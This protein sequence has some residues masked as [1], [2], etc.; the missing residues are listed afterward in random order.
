MFTDHPE[1][2]SRFQE[3]PQLAYEKA[4]TIIAFARNSQADK[5]N[6][7]TVS[8]SL[9]EKKHAI[10]IARGVEFF[11]VVNQKPS[12]YGTTYK[13]SACRRLSDIEEKRTSIVLSSSI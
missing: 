2:A 1:L 11:F 4:G 12:C 13:R 10:L 8:C 3:E 9:M 6:C 5:H 7:V